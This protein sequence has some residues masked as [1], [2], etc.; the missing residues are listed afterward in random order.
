MRKV[1]FLMIILSALGGC[2]SSDPGDTNTVA[3]DNPFFSEWN[4]PFGTPPFDKIEQ[5]HYE[6]AIMEGM[7]VHDEEIQAI[8]SNEDAPTF[9]NTIEAMDRSGALLTKV[10]SVFGAMN[11]TMTNDEMQAIAKRIAP[12]R[13]KHRDGINLNA[14][15]FARVDAV[16]Q[17]RAD[18]GLDVEQAKLLEETWKGFVRGGANLSEADKEKLKALN[19]ELSILSLQFGENVLN[20]TNKFE[21]AVENETGL[22]G[23][24]AASIEGAAE[25]ATKRGHEGQ[26]IFT[27]HKPSLIPFLQY[28]ESRDLR[29]V[30]WRGYTMVGNND[31]ELDNKKILARMANIRLERANLLGFPT[32]AH[33]VL[34]DSMAKTPDNV[35]SLLDQIWK[36]ALARANQEAAD[37]QAMMNTEVGG[38]EFAAWDWWYYAEKVKKAKYDL[39]E[40]TM[41]PYF[42]LESVRQG[43]FEVINKLWGLTFHELSDLPVIT[44]VHDHAHNFRTAFGQIVR[45]AAQ[46]SFVNIDNGDLHTF[47]SKGICQ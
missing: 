42:E 18:L 19:E 7:K 21:M 2:S 26:W 20:E 16:Y 45:N 3:A 12:L 28:A 41:R 1:L 27:L 23:L 4:T 24:P 29:E 33:Y 43:L 40:E 34:D 15:L 31:D 8:A 39:D 17:Q 38:A 37:M 11:G 10:S 9:A 32:H 13:S 46:G 47:L 6:P 36:P 30:M 44:D 14:E 22:A 5:A 35:Y 25:E